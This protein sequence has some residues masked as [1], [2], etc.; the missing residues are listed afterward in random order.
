MPT[1]TFQRTPLLISAGTLVVGP[2]NAAYREGDRAS[3][4]HSYLVLVRQLRGQLRE[5]TITLRAADISAIAGYLGTSDERV[6]DDLLERMGA[7]REQRK[8]LAAMFAI[9]AL[10]IVATGSI[11]LDVASVGVSADSS[12]NDAPA[13][14]VVQPAAAAVA[15]SFPTPAMSDPVAAT[16]SAAATLSPAVNLPEPE[17]AIAANGAEWDLMVASQILAAALAEPSIEATVAPPAERSVA[18]P[19]ETAVA[20]PVEGVG[21]ADDG[22]VVAVGPPPSP[23]PPPAPP[24][25]EPDEGVG[26]ADDG[27]IV[28]VGPPPSVP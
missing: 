6:L 4:L 26:V 13:A 9:G 5:P 15:L 19:V 16:P 14:A 28:A 3:L 1:A 27:S 20:P 12:P 25:T 10:T 21:V 17:L 18:T 7:T 24:L 23:P 11:A 2:V 8:T 22:S